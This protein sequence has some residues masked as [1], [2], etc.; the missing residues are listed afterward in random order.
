MASLSASPI[1]IRNRLSRGAYASLGVVFVVMGAI[2][3]FL[4]VWPTTIFCILALW[5]FKKSS[6]KMEDWLLSNRVV[7]P[8]LRDW[9]ESKSLTRKAKAISITA[10][11]VCIAISIA[12]VSKPWV[13]G[14]LLA[15]AIALTWYLLSRP[16]TVRSASGVRSA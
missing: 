16:T 8:T 2:G 4:P 10:I 11:W 1:P 12:V 13:Q 9:D 14:L 7:G 6:K 15:T 3:V 5:C